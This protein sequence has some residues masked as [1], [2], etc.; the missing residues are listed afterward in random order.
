MRALPGG[1]EGL[2]LWNSI[3]Y[4]YYLFLNT[5]VLLIT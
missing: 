3:L 2:L 4:L 1:A 5:I